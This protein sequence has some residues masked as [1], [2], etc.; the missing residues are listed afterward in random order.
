MRKV[1][2]IVTAGPVPA[3]EAPKRQR[4][5]TLKRQSAETLKHRS[6]E[7][8]KRRSVETPTPKDRAARQKRKEEKM[9]PIEKNTI[10]KILIALLSL[11]LVLLTYSACG[12]APD[13][14]DQG[15]SA[16]DTGTGRD[17]QTPDETTDPA[18]TP[19]QAPTTES[20]LS[21]KITIAG[22]TSVQPLSDVLAQAFS[23]A[24]PG[25]IIDVQG[26]GSGVGITSIE[27]KISDLGSLSREVKDEE[28]KSVQEEYVIAKDGIAVITN[29]G[30]AIDNITMDQLKGVFTGEIKNWKEVGGPDA[31]IVVVAREEGSGTRGAFNELTGV[32]SKDAEGK[33]VDNTVKSAIVQPSTGAVASAV[34][35]SK[36]SIGYIS[37]GSLDDSVKAVKVEDVAAGN[38]TVLDGT[39]KLSRPFL[40]V[41]GEEFSPQAKAYLD[42][43]L[44][45]VGQQIVIDEGYISAQ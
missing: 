19:A 39:Y 26:G 8:P 12:N 21:G 10:I 35:S 15:P 41:R 30:V 1:K 16:E 23:D 32:S 5:E 33:E 36:N 2:A 7:M 22:S 45:P 17:E 25:V 29:E 34:A 13:Q 3:N 40:Y 31:A 4:A 11:T 42:F 20:S 6:A 18:Q 14:A 38:E 9:K 44:G 24:N 37:L 27:Q 43:V 28:K